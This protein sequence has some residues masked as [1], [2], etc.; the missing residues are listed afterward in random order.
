MCPQVHSAKIWPVWEAVE[1]HQVLV[2]VRRGGEGL[3]A[4]L[5]Q[6]LEHGQAACHLRQ[7]L[8]G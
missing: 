8:T 5:H 2:A 4:A 7:P 1:V 3:A 6:A